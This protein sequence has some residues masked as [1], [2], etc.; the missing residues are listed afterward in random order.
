MNLTKPKMP[1]CSVLYTKHIQFENTAL[2]I[3]VSIVLQ[4]MLKH[5]ICLIGDNYAYYIN[6]YATRRVF[7]CKSETISQEAFLF[8][9]VY[10]SLHQLFA[11]SFKLFNGRIEEGTY[12]PLRKYNFRHVISLSKTTSILEGYF[13]SVCSLH[14]L[15]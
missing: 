14:R 11:Q 10:L 3:L 9:V 6:K 13:S 8:C 7:M 4:S 5:A 12:C 2:I 15:V 1:T